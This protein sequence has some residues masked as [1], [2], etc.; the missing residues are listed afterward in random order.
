[1][2]RRNKIGKKKKLAYPKKV[3]LDVVGGILK[4]KGVNKK[5]TVL[6]VA[7]MSAGKSTLINALLRQ[8]LLPSANEATTACITVLH[9]KANAW[10]GA[11]RFNAKGKQLGGIELAVPEK[12]EAWNS[13]SD[14][15]LVYIGGNL[16]A[17]SKLG[18]VLVDTP[19]PNNSQD[20]SHH[21]AF[22]NALS[23]IPHERLI[24][25]LN[26]ANLGTNDCSAVLA[27]I[28]AYEKYPR[29][30]VFVVN[31]K[32]VLN[33][34]LGETEEYFREKAV[35]YLEKAGFKNPSLLFVSARNALLARKYMRNH[36]VTLR[37]SIELELSMEKLEK[38]GLENPV[39]A[40]EL[41][42]GILGLESWLGLKTGN[43]MNV[44][45]AEKLE[46]DA[47]PLN[48]QTGAEK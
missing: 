25:V 26:A 8:E 10:P 19:G 30:I 2:S 24:C 45:G 35:G 40:M 48:K 1:M 32:D 15:H 43:V 31:K 6:V 28:K 34:C 12:I 5:N 23:S 29:R 7:T 14:T 41:E 37:E 36:P 13:D 47:S 39:K 18:L 17:G 42:S 3:N 44:V 11:V 46:G 22:R 16:M 27:A 33:P 38:S 20:A 21:D 9:E 4:G